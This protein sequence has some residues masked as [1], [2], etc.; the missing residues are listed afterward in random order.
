MAAIKFKHKKATAALWIFFLIYVFT[1][2]WFTVLKRSTTFHSARL[3]LFWSY[4]KWLSG[5][6]ELGIEIL[7]NIAMFVPFGFLLTSLCDR[8]YKTL[9]IVTL[10]VCFSLIIETSQLLLMRGLF[11][12]DDLFSNGLGAVLGCWIY[13]GAKKIITEEKFPAIVFSTAVLFVIVCAGVYIGGR[14]SGDELDRTSRAYCFQIDEVE[15]DGERITLTGFAFRYERKP[16][17]INLALQSTDTG[18]R[19]R[20]D[21]RQTMR[22]DVNHYFLCEYDYEPTGFIA[23]GVIDP[24][25]EYEVLI[26][27]PWSMPVSTGVFVTGT[28]IHYVAE[29]D[30]TAPTV[31]NTDLEPIVKNGVLC[32]FRPDHH[33]WVYQYEG[34]LYW[35]ADTDFFFEDDETTYIQYQLYTTQTENLPAYRLEHNWLWDNIGDYFETN[36]L[37]GNFGVYRVMKRAL[38]TAYSITSIV[39]GYYKNG[40]WIWSHY[41]RP[42]Y[43]FEVGG[44]S[45]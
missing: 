8:K 31:E 44:T 40:K 38:P 10:A 2:I 24:T 12:W 13:R 17:S 39:T 5:D 18:K 20:L 23:T 45:R 28:D 29:K 4:R 3:E 22:P 26:Q 9:L 14:E 36:E 32:V 7:G 37:T 19:I 30:F 43:E 35:I 16:V 33:C 34:A 21:S 15:V 1:V 41:F 42:Y 25:E 6:W 27:W 11:E